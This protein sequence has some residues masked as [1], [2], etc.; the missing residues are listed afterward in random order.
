M[1]QS[2]Q[3]SGIPAH[4]GPLLDAIDRAKALARECGVDA[5]EAGNADLYGVYADLGTALDVSSRRAAT[6]KH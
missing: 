5:M 6:I 2:N 1:T 3:N 4:H